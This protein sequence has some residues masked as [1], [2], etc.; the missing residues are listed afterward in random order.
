M[1]LDQASAAC[2]GS[3]YTFIPGKYRLQGM[4]LYQASTGHFHRLWNSH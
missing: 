3:C 4:P 2:K 1:P